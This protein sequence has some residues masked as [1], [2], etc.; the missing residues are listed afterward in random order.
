LKEKIQ[1]LEGTIAQE[2]KREKIRLEKE[3]EKERA[4]L[5]KE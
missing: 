4:Q 1:Y 3:K 5:I 2:K